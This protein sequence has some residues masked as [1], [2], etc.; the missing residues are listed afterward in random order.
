MRAI[1]ITDKK[2]CFVDGFFCCFVFLFAENFLDS[3]SP[4][5]LYFSGSIN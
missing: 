4:L 5:V 3:L 2:F 1:R